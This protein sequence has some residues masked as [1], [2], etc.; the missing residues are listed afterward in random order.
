GRDV[1]DLAPRDRAGR[2]TVRRREFGLIVHCPLQVVRCRKAR[3]RP[4]LQYNGPRTTDQVSELMPGMMARRRRVAR[5]NR[6]T[7]ALLICVAWLVVVALAV[8]RL[9]RADGLLVAS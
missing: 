9:R 7:A 2:G 5:P 3:R 1:H 4:A 8:S 6:R